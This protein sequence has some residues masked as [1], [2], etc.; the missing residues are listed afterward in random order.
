MN[1]TPRGGA[2]KSAQKIGGIAT[3]NFIYCDT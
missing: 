2:Q 1:S 3:H